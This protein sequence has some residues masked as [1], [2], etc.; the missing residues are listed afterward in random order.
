MNFN[1][2]SRNKS[3][4]TLMEVLIVIA[5]LAFISLGIYQ[6]TVQTFGSVTRSRMKASSTT[7]FGW[8]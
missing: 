3:G 8:S 2:P 1:S 7:R 4:F 6:A 5:I